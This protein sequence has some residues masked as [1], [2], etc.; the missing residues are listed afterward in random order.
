MN[1]SVSEMPSALA[2][3]LLT[4]VI[5]P[6]PVAWV[7]TQNG[8]AQVNLAPF[9]YFAP[10]SSNPPLLMFSAGNRRDGSP[11]D[12]VLN[13]KETQRFVVHI[14]NT[15]HADAMSLTAKE[16]PHGESEAELAGLNL[17]PFEGFA[18]P[19]VEGVPVALGCELFQLDEL[20]DTPQN[21]IYGKVVS[22]WL[23]DSLCTEPNNPKHFADAKALDPISRL[24]GDWYAQLGEFIHSPRA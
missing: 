8:Q 19:R 12:T 16:C 24:G 1:L 5:V 20:G 3:Q 11:K 6:R 13:I 14:A 7:L 17:V 4:Q 23:D 2:Y 21:V 18:L 9:S 10:V 22:A 15:S